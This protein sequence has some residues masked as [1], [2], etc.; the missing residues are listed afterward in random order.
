MQRRSNHARRSCAPGRNE[1]TT[2]YRRG[3][4]NFRGRCWRAPSRAINF[5][6]AAWLTQN[7]LVATDFV[8]GNTVF[9]CLFALLRVPALR[10]SLM[11]WADQNARSINSRIDECN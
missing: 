3:V 9:V 7:S 5:L 10:E 1:H 6:A 4:H 8:L 2:K 11:N